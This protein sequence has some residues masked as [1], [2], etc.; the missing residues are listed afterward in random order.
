MDGMQGVTHTS[1]LVTGSELIAA[2]LIVVRP[3]PKSHSQ[4]KEHLPGTTFHPVI[5]RNHYVLPNFATRSTLFKATNHK[6]INTA[7]DAD[8]KPVWIENK[9]VEGYQH[10]YLGKTL[11]L[12]HGIVYGHVIKLC[13]PN[14]Q[15]ENRT[16]FTISSLLKAMGSNTGGSSYASIKNALEALSDCELSPGTES[17]QFEGKILEFG[18]DQ[19]VR[20]HYLVLPE[21]VR[22]LLEKGQYT[23]I[24]SE[25]VRS[26]QGSTAKSLYHFFASHNVPLDNGITLEFLQKHI[27][28][29]RAKKD[30]FKR[31]FVSVSHQ[32]VSSGVLTS[33]EIRNGKLI[34]QLPEKPEALQKYLEKKLKKLQSRT[35]IKTST[36]PPPN[37]KK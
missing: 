8:G 32:L 1:S 30:V 24:N 28:G 11:T 12:F 5:P 17:Q 25:V 2:G 33:A 6:N 20:K 9:G 19:E 31:A 35:N 3:D 26:I 23:I 7:V 22:D 13:W 37:K 27:V 18:Y 34:Y 21:M 14:V 10:F 16:Y 36:R 29:S 4:F 15:S